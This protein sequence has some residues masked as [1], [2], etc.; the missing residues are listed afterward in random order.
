MRS[1]L[2]PAAILISMALAAA[3][4]AV[5]GTVSLAWDPVADSDLAGYRVYYGTTPGSYAQSVD[6]GNVTATTMNNLSDCTMYYFGVKAY[7][8]ANNLS[9]NFSNEISGWSRPTVLT[10][11]P[12]SAEVGR[13]I[14]VVIT[15]TNFQSG[16]VAAFS[17]AGITVN[18]T[19]VNACGQVTANITIG[20]ATVAGTSNIEV[21]N[22]DGVYNTGNNLFTVLAAVAPT[23]SST[24]P[25]NGA[26]GVSIGVRPTVLFSE[27][28]LPT[29]VTASTVRLL[30]DTST[31][32][33]QGAGS[34]SLS[35]DGLTA[36]ITPAANLT[37]GKTY[38]IQV[39][40]GVSG[41]LDLGLHGLAANYLQSTGFSTVSDT[42]APTISAVSSS[43]VT[44]TSAT[45]SWTT[46]EAADS[47]VF[48]RKQGDAAY[49]QTSLDSALVTSHSVPL[50]GLSPSTTYEF[51]VR[52]A[53]SAG[54]AA[55]S[56]PTSTFGTAASSF[57]YLRMEA[58]SGTIVPPMRNVS[59]ASGAFG[60]SY[61]DTPAGTPTGG[62]TSPAGTTT[63]GVNIPTAGTWYLWVRMYGP[64]ATSDTVFESVNGAARA[65]LIAS[66]TGQWVW[67]E[68]R[69]YTLATGIASIEISGRE[70]QAR[71]DRVLITNDIGFVP[72]EQPVGDQTPPAA[73][74]NFNAVG[75][76]AQVTLSWTNPSSS[77]YAQTII[78][79]RTD[80]KHPS[81]PVDGTAVVVEP[82]T[83]GATETFVHTGLING[84]TYYYSA[85]SQDSAGNL[86][87]AAKSSALVTDT[88]PPASVNSLRRSD[89]KL[90]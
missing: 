83:P 57:S 26:S 52:S 69:S 81:S 72:T 18:S 50:A 68:G 88:V 6:V 30:D 25:A 59:S 5:A 23:V 3:A 29:S 58:E 56:S 55:Q 51:Y 8:T 21:T 82:G 14:S 44:A 9:T 67:V 73:D 10:A 31:P 32:V 34:P 87:P 16:A 17:R 80:G 33:P 36:T 22:T 43:S 70:A 15:G 66:S 35:S 46:N 37:Q 39:I 64:D 24:T 11:V 53:D 7:D 54:N 40:G 2:R 62:A 75:A 77:D 85:F 71:V 79:Y 27:A 74:S 42:T 38:R 89:K 63:F 65:N 49:Q 28:M 90:P 13:T 76:T 84:T 4:P 48:Y 12:A 78:R 60:S 1:I 47:Q 19:T 41:V 86:G 45:V 61:V 20:A